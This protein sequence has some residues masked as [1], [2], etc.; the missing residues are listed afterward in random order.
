MN[1]TKQSD[2]IAELEQKLKE[3][4]ALVDKLH[5]EVEE[6]KKPKPWNPPHKDAWG[7]TRTGEV[8]CTGPHSKVA[9]F[10]MHFDTKEAAEKA[11]KA[12]R[13]YHRL[14]KLA[15]E[16]NKGWEPAW[17][18][19]YQAKFYIYLDHTANPDKGSCWKVSIART[20]EGTTIYFKSEAI[21]YKVIQLLD[22]GEV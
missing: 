2:T 5:Q 8:M 21:A 14:Y 15:E 20:S 6:A 9:E 4:Q 11:A 3:A 1:T 10:G 22:R 18:N 16:L 12:Y 19:E 7:V 17:E 13:F